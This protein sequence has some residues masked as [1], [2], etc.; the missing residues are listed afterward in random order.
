[1]LKLVQK[2]VKMLETK[3]LVDTVYSLGKFKDQHPSDIYYKFV[4]GDMI[5]ECIH[6]V[7]DLDSMEIAYLVKGFCTLQP[8]LKKHSQLLSYES[9]FRTMLVAR[10]AE[11]SSLVERMEPYSVSK[12]LRYLLKYNTQL[13]EIGTKVYSSLGL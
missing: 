4:L 13:D 6:R 2:N 9:E 5:K 11:D 8:Y 10:L 12:I 1:M 3:N 7:Q